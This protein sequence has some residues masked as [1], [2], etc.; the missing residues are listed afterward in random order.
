MSRIRELREKA[1]LTQVRLANLCGLCSTHL[2]DFE[3]GTRVPWPLARR[4]LAKVLKCSES[5]LFGNG[6]RDVGS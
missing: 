6:R 3:R 1:G 5:E 2:S 4:R